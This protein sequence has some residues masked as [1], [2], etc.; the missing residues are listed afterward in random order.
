MMFLPDLSLYPVIACDAETTGLQWWRDKVF[1]LAFAWDDGVKLRSIY[2]DIRDGTKFRWA[3]D[4][5]G[6]ARKV[7]NHNIKFD[8]HMLRETHIPV[9]PEICECTMIREALLDEHR[10]S[11]SLD[12]IAHDRL[13]RGKVDIWEELARRFGG[14]ATKDA[15]MPNLQHAPETVVAKYACPDAE[16]ALLLW[17]GQ[18]LE[19][20]KQK[21]EYIADFENRRLL[22]VVI[23]MERRGVRV[24]QERA[25]MASDQLYEMT[26]AARE[27]LNELCGWDVNV[28]SNPQVH[29][30]VQPARDDMGRWRAKDGTPLEDTDGG[31]PSVRTSALHNMRF[32]EAHL[33]AQIRGW[34]K[35]R[36]VFIDRYILKDA[37]RGYIHANINQ[38]KTD[39]EAG[40]DG[41]SGTGTGRFSITEPA[42]QQIHAR[43][44]KL[45]EVVR[46]CFLPDPGQKWGSFDYSQIDFRCFVHFVNQPVLTRAYADNPATDFHGLISK[47]INIPRDRD[48]RTGGANS[49]QINLGLI[50]G[51]GGGRLCREM[52]LPYFVDDK[53]FLRAGDEGE[54][55]FKRYHGTVPGIRKLTKNAEALAKSR[56]YILTPLGRRLHFPWENEAYKAAG[57]LFQGT[58]AD[59]IKYKMVELYEQLQN[60]DSRLMLTVHDELCVSMGPDCDP[61]KTVELLQRFD[62]DVTPMK[63]RVPILCKAGVGDNWFLATKK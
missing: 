20:K 56:G 17:R 14:A 21:L 8:Q 19:I 2:V 7:V 39:Y 60:T 26:I 5:L 41:T 59:I 15:Q 12:S 13:G 45:A 42:L 4:Q 27:R 44:V 1:G 32:E 38:T 23:D 54:A 30:I 3:R 46:S 48:E 35:A 24:D 16:L 50:F 31:G 22:P 25:A 36:E 9:K 6:R 62:G 33:V 53:G 40:G 47:L 61:V 10:H 52:G 58:C 49:K 34:I 57:L 11:Y 28:N 55:I 37:F 18:E 51:M 29:K 43:D 63:F